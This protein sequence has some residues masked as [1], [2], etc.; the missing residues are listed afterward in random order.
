M[1]WKW[2][3]SILEAVCCECSRNFAGSTAIPRT[4]FYVDNIASNLRE[5]R[6]YIVKA[7]RWDSGMMNGGHHFDYFV[8]SFLGFVFALPSL[9]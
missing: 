7:I 9:V 3:L 2:T 4:R 8:Y 5:N 1:G 6:Q